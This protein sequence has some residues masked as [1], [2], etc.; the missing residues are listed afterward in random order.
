MNGSN[1]H[2]STFGTPPLHLDG[3]Y[4]RELAMYYVGYEASKQPAESPLPS[5]HLA[6]AEQ[7]VRGEK[8]PPGD[9]WEMLA[10]AQRLFESTRP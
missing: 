2:H 7:F 5:R 1:R 6:V 3:K 8:S 9:V 10:Y 4:M